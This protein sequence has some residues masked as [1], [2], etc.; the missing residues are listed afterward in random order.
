M[1]TDVT[2]EVPPTVRAMPFEGGL[3]L[4]DEQTGRAVALNATATEVFGLVDRRTGLE[5]IVGSL[6]DKYA[7]P[8]EVVRAEIVSAVQVLVDHG[9]VRAT[10]S[11][12][13]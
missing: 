9:F 2:L 3:S 10:V 12:A 8:R 4:F 1:E 6:C 13:A 7:V 11:G 5:A